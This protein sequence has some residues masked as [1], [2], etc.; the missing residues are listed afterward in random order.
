MRDSSNYLQIFVCNNSLGKS[1]I[2]LIFSHSFLGK[3]VQYVIYFILLLINI[4]L[5]NETAYIYNQFVM[6]FNVNY[7]VVIVMTVI[8][9]IN[10]LNTLLQISI[11]KYFIHFKQILQIV[12]NWY[13]QLVSKY[14]E[15]ILLH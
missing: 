2:H 7:T 10:F 5:Q 8:Y 3:F 14:I 15:L 4:Y 11:N 9:Y 12:F 13:Y 1:F 6:I